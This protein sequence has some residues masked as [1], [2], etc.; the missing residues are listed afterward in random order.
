MSSLE[1]GAEST[2]PPEQASLPTAP[3]AQPDL[4]SLKKII[5]RDG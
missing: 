3:T 4:A 5:T 1:Q 2:H